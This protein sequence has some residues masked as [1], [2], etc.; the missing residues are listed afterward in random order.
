METGRV[1]LI[2]YTAS[3]GTPYA[4]SGLLID[5]STVLTAD[6]VAAGRDYNIDC[7]GQARAVAR[8]LRSGTAAVDLAVLTLSEPIAGVGPI[9][10]A[11]VDRGRIA[12]VADCVTVGFPR[13]RK[14]GDQR[15]SAQVDGMIPTAEGLEPTADSG[16]RAGFLT[17]VGDRI[18]GAPQISPG[19]VAYTA[20]SPWGGMS[21]A[22]VLT[23]DLLIGVIRSHNLA[24]GG[25]SLTI[26]PITSISDLPAGIR[27][28]FWDALGIADPESIQTLPAITANT[29][30]AAAPSRSP[31]RALPRDL[32]D[33]T[34][35]EDEVAF[36]LRKL[37]T[38]ASAGRAVAIHAVNGM[39]G[40]G[41]TSLAVHVGHHLQSQYSDALFLDLRAH[42]K[43]QLP[44]EPGYALEVLL[45]ML[46]VPGD[47]I[48]VQFDQRVARWRT[49]L[50]DRRA[51]I[52]LDNAVSSA[53]VR[54]LLPAS[55]GSL[56][57]ITSRVRLMGLEGVESVSLEAMPA[58]DAVEL[59]A[60]IVGP[61]RVAAEPG[62]AT[63]I[64]L[65]CGYLPL[66]I[67]LV[68]SWLR[69]H[70]ARSIADAIRRLPGTLSAVSA[71]FELSYRDLD[72]A[73][74][75]MFR[76]LA[77][78]PGQ[79][80]TRDTAAVLV[81]AD[82]DQAEALLDELYDRHLIEEPRAGRYQFHDL[83]RGYAADLAADR[84][85]EPLRQA[86]T[87]RLIGHYIDAVHDHESAQDHGWF[88]DEMPEL[89][90]CA[91]YAVEK[92]QPD[93]AW[94]FPRALAVVL[95]ARGLYRQASV[96]HEGALK[97]ARAHGDML[98]QAGLLIDL[99]I[100]ER[101]ADRRD[102]AMQ[103]ARVALE[104]YTELGID[105]GQASAITELGVI[106]A[107]IG[108]PRNARD[109]LE[110]ARASYRALGIVIGQGNVAMALTNLSRENGDDEGAR[111]FAREALEL[112]EQAGN[113]HGQAIAHLGLA[114]LSVL[115][116]DPAGARSHF[117]SAVRFAAESGLRTTEAAAHVELGDMDDRD[118]EQDS[119]YQHWTRARDIDLEIGDCAAL[120][121]VLER[122]HGLES[123]LG[124]GA[125]RR[126]EDG[127][128]PRTADMFIESASDPRHDPP[129]APCGA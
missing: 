54:P 66:A 87:R 94:R 14:D 116:A 95:Q 34:G 51:L 8:V 13:W 68:A 110:Q 32:S 100:V 125:T 50:S 39:A 73:Q 70:P 7:A 43:D 96:L 89:L 23:G 103:H 121:A 83:I 9:G 19:M 72:D 12:Q 75:L 37:S 52:V 18:P 59:L 5:A 41:K 33:F 71:A 107:E 99:S 126:T 25:Q 64:V 67:R 1:A 88:E 49:E 98:A 24:A 56:L 42:T 108:E 106:F 111:S 6:H 20:G 119:A 60:R 105:W 29:P 44:L 80:L 58:H 114:S 84:D 57:I 101:A 31:V 11:R 40:I 65:R 55:P 10:F 123:P 113:S 91:H 117:S 92:G 69:H 79:T 45:S 2:R 104:I 128:M 93:S 3:N 76:R 22:G 38:M 17:L 27:Q 124:K 47:Q 74:Q 21:G 48:P 15:R 102:R 82:P 16:L 78:H 122:L 46:G 30:A 97:A 109:Y 26:T 4:G 120:S 118:G 35:R 36:L 90:S 127:D 77:L 112:Y 129:P 53:Q 28:Q 81:D 63:A 85:S 115:A 62:P 61:G 86:A